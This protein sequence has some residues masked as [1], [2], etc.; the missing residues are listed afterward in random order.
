M[1]ATVTVVGGG[2]GGITAARALDGEADVVLVEPRDAFVHNVAALRALVDPSWTDKIFFPYD[3]LLERGRVLRDR[4]AR[5]DESG[6]TLG[7]GERIESD[8]LVLATGS[9]YPFPAKVDVDDSAAS[10]LTIR[11]TGDALAGAGRVL[12]LGAGPAGLELAGEIK[13][14]WPD[15]SVTIVDPADHILTGG[16]P[17]ELRAE[18]RAQ[19]A[20]MGVELLLGTSLSEPPP[21][22]PGVAKSFTA[23]TRSG[24]EVTA[25]IWF[26]CFGVVPNSGY[27]AGGLAGARRPDGHVEVGPD[28]RLP[29]QSRV[30][31]I[32]DLTA[33][34]ESKKAKAAGDHAEVVVANIRA[35]I[36][37]DDPKAAYALPE[38]SIALPL[39]PS[40]GASYSAESGVLGAEVTAGIKGTDLMV[41]DYRSM[42][43][44]G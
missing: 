10:K 31:A 11:A 6:V 42:F 1:T 21:S 37:G 23:A 9:G 8:Y 38:P 34:P 40:G 25:D 18:L 15:K 39:G 3:G 7:S 16:Y 20:A 13:A 35:L 24:A 26:R 41:D 30:F 33:V 2:Y 14:A 17:E 32:G 12:L 29:G 4:V 28:L 19:L 43:G 22:E 44:L 36:A 5:A 27:L